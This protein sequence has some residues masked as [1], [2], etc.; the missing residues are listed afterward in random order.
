[1]PQ[2]IA[3]QPGPFRVGEPDGVRQ[4]IDHHLQQPGA[5]TLIPSTSSVCFLLADCVNVSIAAVTPWCNQ[6]SRRPGV[7]LPASV[8]D[9]SRMSLLILPGRLR[10]T[11]SVA[12]RARRCVSCGASPRLCCQ[13]RT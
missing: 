2:H 11:E 10:C 8:L 1:M 7:G 13:R 6:N 9:K 12:C 3:A 4:R 5:V